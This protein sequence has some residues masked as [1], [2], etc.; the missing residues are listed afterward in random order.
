M[1][2]L[3]TVGYPG[4]VK[5]RVNKCRRNEFKLTERKIIILFR[6]MAMGI[7]F[8]SGRSRKGVDR[9]KNGLVCMRERGKKI[10]FSFFFLSA[11]PVHRILLSL[12][13]FSN[14]KA[15]ENPAV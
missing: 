12:A 15:V 1:G 7:E 4:K 13:D 8:R 10:C 2:C 9:E 5:I 14:F 11:E 3:A 6:V